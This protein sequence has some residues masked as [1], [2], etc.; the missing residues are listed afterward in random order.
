MTTT[1]SMDDEEN[2]DSKA[3]TLEKEMDKGYV[4]QKELVRLIFRD[5]GYVLGWI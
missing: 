1:M 5:S 3:Q 4:G 2:V